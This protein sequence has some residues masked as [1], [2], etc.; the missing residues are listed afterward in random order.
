MPQFVIHTV[1]KL[2]RERKG[3][4]QAS[5]CQAICSKEQMYR[6]EKGL[7]RPS[8]TVFKMLMERLEENP[9]KY[10]TDIVTADRK[11]IME[12]K[13][14][15]LGM[16]R[17]KDP[18]ED[19]KAEK[20]VKR[21]EKA[22]KHRKNILDRQFLYRARATIAGHKK[23]WQAM[24]DYAFE[25]LN[26]TIKDFKEDEIDQS[27]ISFDEIHL[28]NQLATAR[29][30]L[31]PDLEAATNIYARLKTTLD[32]GYLE[33]DEMSGI[34]FNLLYNLSKNL[35]LL[36]RY[37]E[38][39][40]LCDEGIER[41]LN[42]KEALCYPLF[43]INKACGVLHLGEEKEGVRILRD[44]HALLSIYKRYNELNTLENFIESDF[45]IK[46]DLYRYV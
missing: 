24:Y 30:F 26:L 37:E 1:I 18:D 21:L 45:G 27:V 36:K 13:D 7:H 40:T 23:E 12:Q 10:Y 35:G 44:A 20:I 31:S 4:T 41:C 46:P 43:L 8:Y 14:E 42:Q 17:K 6:I 32:Y 29:N 2:L 38:S 28:I 9:D 19:L 11:E 16:L 22:G 39:I 5:L 33:G 3:Y 25:G 15:I 34:Y